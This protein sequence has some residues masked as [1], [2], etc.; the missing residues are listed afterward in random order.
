M[1]TLTY[2]ELYDE[3]WHQLASM[4]AKRSALLRRLDMMAKMAMDVSPVAGIVIAMVV[5]TPESI[6][7]V[8]AARRNELQ[9]SLNLALGSSLATIGLT[10]P[11]V[12]IT[13]IFLGKQ[14]E[15]GLSARDT[16]LLALT[17]FLSLLTF[18]S[19]RTNILAGLVHL[20]VR[21]W[22]GPPRSRS[23]CPP[24]RCGE[25]PALR[26]TTRSVTSRRRRGVRTPGS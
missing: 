19:G 24:S 2:R 20:V 15:L 26:G 3:A 4:V 14:I 6:T 23:R 17:L 10:I 9:K 8:R 21:R 5:L 12:A 22:C 16:L 7:A 25:A 13:N 11:A 18:G 1:P